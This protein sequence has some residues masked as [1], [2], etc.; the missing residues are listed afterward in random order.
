MEKFRPLTVIIVLF[1]NE[2]LKYVDETLEAAFNIKIEI[3]PLGG[4][5]LAQAGLF[6]GSL[7]IILSAFDIHEQWSKKISQE[8]HKDPP[9][10]IPKQPTNPPD[11]ME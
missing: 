6:F 1:V 5:G 4:S 2:L 9:K 8:I 11:K 7:V 10:N 3:L